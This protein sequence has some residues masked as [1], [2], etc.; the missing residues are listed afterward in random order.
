MVETA[1]QR[2][3]IEALQHLGLKEYEAKC[4]VALTQMDSGTARD[5]SDR[6]DV[7]RTRVYE[8][9]RVLEEQGLIEVQH[10]SPQRYRAIDHD[11]AM[12]VLRQR[13][14]SRFKKLEENLSRLSDISSKDD[15]IDAQ[16]IWALTDRSAIQSRTQ[17]LLRDAT[18][19]I[20]LVVGDQRVLSEPL[21]E[22]LRTATANGIP[23]LIGAG[24][25]EIR[26]QLRE[27]VPD[28]QIFESTLTWLR[29]EADVPTV[30]RLLMVDKQALLASTII[31]GG[32]EDAIVEHAVFGTGF[33]NSLVVIVR[34][35]LMTG[36]P[37]AYG[38]N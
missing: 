37:L 8:A 27:Q 6:I 33:G 3:A 21:F 30:G 25:E 31:E 5:I 23:V 18:E 28:G 9:T 4:F 17:T 2:Q 20:V 7:P 36:G 35:L 24:S 38:D 19:E 32:D 29:R 15:R 1:S 11:E 13:Y 22:T 26:D 14:E 10:A 16:E 34:R 12:Q